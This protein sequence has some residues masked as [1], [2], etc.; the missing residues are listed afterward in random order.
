MAPGLRIATFVNDEESYRAMRASFAAAGFMSPDIVYERLSD[1]AEDPYAAIT[2]LGN[3][4]E[5]YVMLVHQDVRCDQEHGYRDL[6][7][8]IAEL[9]RHDPRW[10]V[11]GNAGGLADRSVLRHISDPWG[12]HWAAE[13]P[14]RVVTLDEN[15]LVLRT[16]RQ[17][18]CSSALS[19][20][21]LYGS[22]V[23]LNAAC[24]G[25]RCYVIDFRVTHL[26]A[27]D[28]TGMYEAQ[29]RLGQVWGRRLLWPRYVR[30]PATVI[31]LATPAMLRHVLSRLYMAALPIAAWLR[32]APAAGPPQQP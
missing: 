25:D 23:C 26:S 3:S 9:E 8:A 29:D 22:D 31:T 19:G 20:F 21:H 24:A 30:A 6:Q 11:A 32:R 10:A 14:R 12:T 18:R 27:G 28:W 1:H 16:A 7:H 5:P 2:R 4:A 17:P 15:L 13:L